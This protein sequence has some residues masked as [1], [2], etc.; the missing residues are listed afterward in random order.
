MLKN[1]SACNGK[2]CIAGRRQRAW[3]EARVGE[4][5]TDRF[6]PARQ[7]GRRPWAPRRCRGSNSPSS[8]APRGVPRNPIPASSRGLAPYRSYRALPCRAA[9]R[10]GGSNAFSPYRA[11][12]PCV[13]GPAAAGSRWVAHAGSSPNHRRGGCAALLPPPP[14]PHRVARVPPSRRN[15]LYFPDPLPR[16]GPCTIS[17]HFSLPQSNNP[18]S[19]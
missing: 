12:V 5:R 16:L 14:L 15:I 13:R 2:I 19:Q 8:Q 11:V 1:W 3:R 7:L 9:D 6:K 10:N 17:H 18:A 4:Q